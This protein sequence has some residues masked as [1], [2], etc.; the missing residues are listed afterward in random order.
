MSWF[1]WLFL[2]ALL[3]LPVALRLYVGEEPRNEVTH[4]SGD[5]DQEG[6]AGPMLATGRAR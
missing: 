2:T 6:D 4:E 5:E 1:L 3:V